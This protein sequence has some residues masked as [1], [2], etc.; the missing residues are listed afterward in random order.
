[1]LDNLIGN[2]FSG[3]GIDI[4]NNYI[5]ALVCESHTNGAP[6]AIP[7]ARNNRNFI[8]QSHVQTPLCFSSNI[9]F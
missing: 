3:R 6:D 9:R 7:T 2:S 8:F 5:C 4:G 1:V